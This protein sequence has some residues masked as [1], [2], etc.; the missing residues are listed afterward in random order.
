MDERI[1]AALP[2]WWGPRVGLADPAVAAI[3]AR[4]SGGAPASGI[5]VWVNLNALIATHPP[6]VLRVYR[7]WAQ[8][9]RILAIRRLRERLV[10]A[11]CPW[12]ALI[13]P[14]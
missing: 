1:E 11:G 8:R 12:G 5:G 4:V 3:V 2:P 13:R 9:P 10:A 6:R 7:P 14:Q